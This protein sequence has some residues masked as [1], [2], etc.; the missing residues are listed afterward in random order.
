MNL[1]RNVLSTVVPV[2]LLLALCRPV[3][4][5]VPTVLDF[6]SSVS[7]AG[8]NYAGWAD[9][10][11]ALLDEQAA[12]TFWSNDGTSVGGN[13]PRDSVSLVVEN[14]LY[15]VALGDPSY[16]NM[17]PVSP[18]IFTNAHV[19]VR[20]WFSSDQKS[21]HRVVPDQPIAAVGYAMIAARVPDGSVATAQL[22]AGAV[23]ADKLAASA[24][25]TGSIAPGAV[26]GAELAPDAALQNL[27]KSG[28]IGLSDQPN[29]TN[30]QRAG[31]RRIGTV[32]SDSER[33]L[34]NSNFVA[35]P[36]GIMPPSGRGRRCWFSAEIQRLYRFRRRKRR[37]ATTH[38]LMPGPRWTFLEL[39]RERAWWGS[40][41]GKKRSCSPRAPTST[42]PTTQ[43]RGPG[44]R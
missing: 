15:Q 6:Q 19:R 1:P 17:K 11:F 36:R 44:A 34:T 7:V 9:F 24:V 40:G 35:S 37:S 23:T 32:Q 8:T 39:S 26:G 42:E 18:S 29:A 13:E 14:G 33:W 22:A 16:G 30:L 20:V 43:P 2:S 25:T 12:V 27:Q 3:A 28:G 4:A 31:Y 41:Q 21:F 5:Q 38:T 10:K